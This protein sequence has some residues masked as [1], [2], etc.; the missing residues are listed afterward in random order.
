MD[1]LQ[2]LSDIASL[3][4]VTAGSLLVLSTSVGLVRF[5]DSMSRIHAVTKP[6]TAGLVLTVLGA[7][8][9]VL[10]MDDFTRSEAGD[11]GLLAM[12]L[13]FSF[14]TSP[15]TAQRM[16]RVTRREG[17]YAKKDAMYLNEAPAERALRKR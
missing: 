7:F 12:M 10:T 11:L 2:L 3:L 6:Q 13:L 8:L 15:V 14:L 5:R 16:G 9:R 1:T 4:L 17:L